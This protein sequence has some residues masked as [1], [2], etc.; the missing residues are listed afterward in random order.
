MNP[1][2][3]KCLLVSKVLVADG[4]MQDEE[5]SF[6]EHMM[7]ALGLTDAERKSVVE[8]EGLDAAPGI[9]RALPAEERQAIVEMLVDAASADGKLSPHEMATVRRVTVALGL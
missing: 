8:L 9:V 2:V 4:M 3:A 5:R 6:L 7:K 1:N